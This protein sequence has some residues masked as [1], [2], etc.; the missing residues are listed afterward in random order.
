MTIE[1]V[2]GL[3]NPGVEY[4][5]TRHNVGFM[6]V[7]AVAQRLGA[8][9]WRR[10]GLAETVRVGNLWLARPQ[11][12]MNRSG[13]AVAELVATLG[14]AGP[15]HVLVVAD[16]LDLPLGR[17]RLRRSGGPGTHNGLRDIVDRVGPGFPRLKVGIRGEQLGEDL[18]DW[19]TSP[20]ADDE[21]EPAAAA[22]ERAA[23][24]V[25]AVLES[26]LTAAMNRFNRA[27]EPGTPHRN[28]SVTEQP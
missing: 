24:A 12:Y 9:S 15:E 19:V 17:I 5:E 20:F 8:L 25:L 22:V 26:G 10:G 6:V 18:A 4:R 1:L 16:D 21:R 7:G 28:G 13:A 2:V 3:G 11:T 14:L 27:P 23:E